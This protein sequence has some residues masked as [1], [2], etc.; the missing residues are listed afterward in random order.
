MLE[1]NQLTMNNSKKC[2]REIPM[3]KSGFVRHYSPDTFKFYMEQ[4]IENVLNSCEQRQ[5]RKNQL[6]TELKLSNLPASTQLQI[7]QLLIQKESN[8]IRL[9]RTK[10]NKDMFTKIKTIG[11]GAFGEVDLVQ[12]NDRPNQLFAMKTMRKLKILKQNQIAHVKA[13]RDIMAEAD[14]EWIVKLYFS[15]QDNEYL[16]LVMEYIPG[17][18][19]MTL[20]IRYEIFSEELAKFYASELVIAIETVHKMGFIHRDIKPDNILIDQHGHIKLT[21]FG[22]CTGFRWTHDSKIYSGEKTFL[23]KLDKKLNN[24]TKNINCLI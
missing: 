12:R 14:N 22:L 13:E 19:L 17:G 8:Y 3:K 6:E 5:T 21:D 24:L 9:Q 2:E 7:R 1:I 16:Y 4:H 18:D 10:I 23:E 15:F 20:L 11:C